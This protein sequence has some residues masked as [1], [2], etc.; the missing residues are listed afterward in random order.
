MPMDTGTPATRPSHEDTTRSTLAASWGAFVAL[1]PHV[2]HHVGLLAGASLLVGA[3]GQ[4][5]F[6]VIGLVASVPFLV[7]LKRRFGTWRAPGIAVAVMVVGFS[8]S[9]LVV[10]P[11]IGHHAR[12]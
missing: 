8:V 11:M 6:G 7:R 4:A 3:T 12:M 9:A 10:A 1:L 5:L 2:L